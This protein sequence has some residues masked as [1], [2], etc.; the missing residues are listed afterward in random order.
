MGKLTG[1]KKQPAKNQKS[2]MVWGLGREDELIIE[3]GELI[4][5]KC[6][7]TGGISINDQLAKTC[8]KCHG[9]KKVDWI[10]NAMGE[11]APKYFTAT[12]GKDNIT[13][14]ELYIN[15]TPL[16]KYILDIMAKKIAKEVDKQILEKITQSSYGGNYL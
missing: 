14:S 15:D 6:D 5:D 3:D 8:P 4:C 13:T 10:Q 12:W 7:G 9:T 2:D 11:Q 16:D 1:L